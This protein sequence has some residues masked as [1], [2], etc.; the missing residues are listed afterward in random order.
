MHRHGYMHNHL[1]IGELV[2]FGKD[3]AA[4]RGE[5]PPELRGVEYIDALI[6]TLAGKQLLLHTNRKLHILR[7]HVVKPKLH[8]SSAPF[9]H[10]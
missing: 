3:H 2:F 9:Q 4:V 7:V 8:A 5:E 10:V 1:V 6:V